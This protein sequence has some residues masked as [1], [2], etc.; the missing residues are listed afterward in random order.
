MG[1]HGPPPKREGGLSIDRA[2]RGSMEG[3]RKRVE[4]LSEGERV[5]TQR[6]AWVQEGVRNRYG[7]T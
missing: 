5:V 7:N 2:H 6:Y 1:N 3:L 4:F